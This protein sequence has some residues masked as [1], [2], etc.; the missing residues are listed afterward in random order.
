MIFELPG[1]T[2]ADS[3]KKVESLD[4]L[5]KASE[6]AYFKDKGSVWVKLVITDKDHQ[7]PVVEPVG[8]LVAQSTILVS[9]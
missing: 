1:F 5:R 8:R 6:N 3:G 2:K 7:G 9:R 4:A